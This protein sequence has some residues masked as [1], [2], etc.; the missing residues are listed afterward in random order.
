MKYT[1]I[2]S[3]SINSKSPLNS[4]NFRHEYPLIVSD[5]LIYNSLKKFYVAVCRS[6]FKR[7]VEGERRR[8]TK[9]EEEDKVAAKEEENEEHGRRHNRENRSGHFFGN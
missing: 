2:N 9:E 4:P 7:E 5:F 1:P 8:R 6:F 3:I